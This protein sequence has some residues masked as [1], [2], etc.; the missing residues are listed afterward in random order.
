VPAQRRAGETLSKSKRF[1]GVTQVV[2]LLALSSIPSTAKTKQ[3]KEKKKKKRG[4]QTRWL[5]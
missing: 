5:K 1:G 4:S 2:E 3:N